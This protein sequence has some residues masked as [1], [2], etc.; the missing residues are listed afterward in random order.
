MAVTRL[1]RKDRRNKAIANNKVA[2]IKH[3]KSRPTIQLVD[4]EA[5]KAEFAAKA[6]K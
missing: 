1:I 5:I 3:L 4:I 6:A 2:A